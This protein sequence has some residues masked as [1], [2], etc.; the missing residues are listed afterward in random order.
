MRKC[1][2][3]NIPLTIIA[4]ILTAISTQ[5]FAQA[6]SPGIFFQAVARDSYANPAKDRQIYVVSSIIQ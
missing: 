5:S 2:K 4:F 6:T 3:V 1:F